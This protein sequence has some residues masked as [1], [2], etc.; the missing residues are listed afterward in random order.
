MSAYYPIMVRLFG[1]RCVVV[2]GGAVAERKTIAL[3]EGGADD[4]IVVA[5]QV[6]T[7]LEELAAAGC[8]AL[9]RREYQDKDSE[10]AFLLIA[11]TNDR[12]LN[13][14]IAVYAEK[15]GLLVN[16]AEMGE[17]GSFITP[18]VVRRGE[19]VIALTTG[20]ASPALTA[21][22]RRRLAAQYGQ[23][24]EPFLERLHA[25]RKRVLAEVADPELRAAVLRLAAEELPNE[26]DQGKNDFGRGMS[27]GQIDFDIEEWMTKLLRAAERGR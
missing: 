11:A 19:L 9:L 20:G 24:Y 25:L 12:L 15:R 3:L 10:G 5:P 18:S 4:L 14:G 16:T 27:S 26:D 17:A 6:T 7:R 21:L 22:L 1:K 23:A 2:G 8:I 13:S